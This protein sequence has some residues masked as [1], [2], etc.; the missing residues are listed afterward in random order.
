MIILQ[1]LGD[2]LKFKLV[3]PSRSATRLM[4]SGIQIMSFCDV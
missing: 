2:P 1:S 4:V 3:G